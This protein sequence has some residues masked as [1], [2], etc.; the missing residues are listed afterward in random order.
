MYSERLGRVLLCLGVL[1]AAGCSVREDRTECPCLLILSFEPGAWDGYGWEEIGWSVRSDSFFCR[2]CV[3]ADDVPEE[4]V[5]E[6]PREPVTMTVAAGDEGLFDPEV[7]LRIPEGEPCPPFYGL[8]VPVDGALPEVRVPVLLHKRYASLDVRLHDLG[9][10][11]LRWT[12]KGCVCGYGPGLEPVRGPFSVAL[13]PDAEGR[14]RVAIPA[15]ED[16]T[17]TLCAYRYGELD[18]IFA[19]GQYILESGYDWD[20]PDLE[21]IVLEIDYV[22][23]AARIKINQWSKTLYFTIAV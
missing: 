17:L 13:A 8:A 7:G 3:P 4:Y 20:A 19:I 5:V 10:A 16:G 11:G 18:R 2:G 21:D 23:S 22:D 9:Q 1:L 14:C 12:L 15:Q 6:V